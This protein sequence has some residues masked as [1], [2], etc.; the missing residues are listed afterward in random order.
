MASTNKNKQQ[1]VGSA[2]WIAAEQ[3]KEETEENKKEEEDTAMRGGE[4]G[5]R[6]DQGETTVEDSLQ[7]GS[8]CIM[9]KRGK[10]YTTQV[11]DFR[12]RH[13]RAEDAVDRTIIPSLSSSQRS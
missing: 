4:T 8:S 1:L 13:F 2:A 9:Y 3:G 10:K 11:I 12:A 7:E 5:R 6:G